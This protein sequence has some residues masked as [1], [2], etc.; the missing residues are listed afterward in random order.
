M[1]IININ[2]NSYKMKTLKTLTLLFAAILCSLS[3]S[4]QTADEI[5]GKYIQAV[6]GKD[7]LTKITSLYT[8][9]TVDIMGM[10]GTIKSTT[11][12]GKGMR[13]NIWERKPRWG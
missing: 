12:N 11:L 10:L 1:S 7:K 5:I 8:E 6:G 3:S 13:Q 9:S 4:A 2:L